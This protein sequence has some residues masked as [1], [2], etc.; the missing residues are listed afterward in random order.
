M[1]DPQEPAPIPGRKRLRSIMLALTLSGL[2]A[3]VAALLSETVLAF[4]DYPPN[5][6][7]HQR[8]FVEYDSLRGWRNIAD[9]HGRYVTPEFAVEMSYNARS[10]RGPLHSYDKPASTFRVLLLGDSYLEGYTVPLSDRVAEVTERL[11]NEKPSALRAEVIALGTGGYSTDQESLWFESDGV[12]YQPDL[13]VL[14]FC[15]NDVWYNAQPMYPRG[16]KPLFRMSGDSLVL[17][18]VPVPRMPMDTIV[19]RM[20]SLGM[21]TQT[22][23][24]VRANSHLLRLTEQ[25]VQRSPV[26]QQL[27]A[28]MSLS[29]V[30]S[31]AIDIAGKR[32]T[33]P[34]EYSVFAD[35]T[36]PAAESSL[37]ITQRLLTRLQRRSQAVGAQFV[38]MLVPPTEALYPPGA[39]RS[40]HFHVTSFFDDKDRVRERFR[41]LCAAAAIECT[42][43]TDEFIRAADSLAVHR[44]FVVFPIDQHWNE[45]GHRVAAQSLATLVRGRMEQKRNVVASHARGSGR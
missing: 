6:T 35:S 9:G 36:T 40:A 38:A 28:F 5:Y 27:G 33:I 25:A 34:A 43:P 3:L 15:G 13:V 31:T 21:W 44:R 30:P 26:L 22:K 24:F 32:R 7:D 18:N 39:T 12:R 4:A 14:L 11:L 20:S 16:P 37:V 42:D 10:Y 23:R 2:A 29:S 41:V 45:H 1:N 19:P 8:L 17:T